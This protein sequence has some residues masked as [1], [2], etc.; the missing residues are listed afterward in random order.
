MLSA[1]QTLLPRLRRAPR[2]ITTTTPFGFGP[3]SA[4]ELLDAP[5]R[6][7]IRV[8]LEQP[9]DVVLS[10]SVAP[11]PARSVLV[12]WEV[13]CDPRFTRLERYGLL[14]AEPHDRHA[15]RVAVSG[16]EAGRPYWARFWAGG[17]W[18]ATVRL[19]TGSRAR[20]ASSMAVVS[21]A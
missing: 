5:F 21:P 19:R 8:T 13:A 17:A 6:E 15:V 18:S 12:H 1:A 2:P 4:F 9:G 14:F 16:L 3:T 10:T 7:G 11:S 20:A